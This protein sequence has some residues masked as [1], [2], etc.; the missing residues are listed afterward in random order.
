MSV[1]AH[2]SSIGMDL[3]S[4]KPRDLRDPNAS[5]LHVCPQSAV[6]VDAVPFSILWD[7]EGWRP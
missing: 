7:C 2:G 6:T 3:S 5:A 1:R 4:R